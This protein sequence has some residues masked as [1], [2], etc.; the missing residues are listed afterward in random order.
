M[1]KSNNAI[2]FSTYDIDFI[3]SDYYLQIGTEVDSDYTYGL[4]ERFNPSF[5]LG[6]GKWTIFNRDRG[7][8]I[9]R[10]QGKQTYGYYPFYLQREANRNFHINYFRSSNAL[11]VIKETKDKRHFLT[12]KV[13][14][15]IIDFRF[16][17]NEQ[18]AELTL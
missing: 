8:V 2:L 14:G 17:L 9:D 4:G 1:R 12:Y 16:F 3:Y 15:G 5:R 11:D 6:D 13:I 18:S 7:Q 10:G